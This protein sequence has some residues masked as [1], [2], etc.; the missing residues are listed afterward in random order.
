M[1]AN[2]GDIFAYIQAMMPQ[3]MEGLKVTLQV[4]ALTLVLSVPLGIVVALCRL[5]LERRLTSPFEVRESAL[6][7]GQY[8]VP[9]FFI[10]LIY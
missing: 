7:S 9:G 8:G 10:L 1:L 4:F 6:I 3:M 5:S 2:L